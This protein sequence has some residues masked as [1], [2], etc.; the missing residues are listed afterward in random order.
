MKV[1]Q[2]K[3]IR[4]IALIGSSRSGKTT[5]AECM[6][7]EGGVINRRGSVDDKNAV[8]DYRDIEIDRQSSVYSVPL[9]AQF[10]NH[11]INFID[12]PGFPDFSGEV[13]AAQ[14]VTEASLLFINGYNGVEVGTE[15]AWRTATRSNAAVAIVVNH[16]NHEKVNFEDSVNQLKDF[17]GEKVILAQYPINQGV[18]FDSIIDILSMKML[19]FP[20]AVG[21]TKY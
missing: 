16:M 13:I 5:V 11:K 8:S 1:Y 19:K 14:Y 21:N 12:T 4:N 20:K 3:E 10:Q 17:F 9:Y 15:I 2:T 6:L 18:G 7:F